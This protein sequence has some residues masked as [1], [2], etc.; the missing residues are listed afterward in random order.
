M[1]KASQRP[2]I[3][4]NPITGPL[5]QRKCACGGTPGPTGECEECRKK[6]EAATMQRA[7]TSTAAVESVPPVVH[8][9][10]SSPGEPL[11]AGTR[12]S[13]EPRFGHDFSQVRVHSDAKAAE[14][15]R[16]VNAH[17]YTVG[18]NVVFASGQYM[19]RSRN[20]E[21]LLAHE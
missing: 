11:D 8:E 13:M 16:A 15:A 10:L 9:V 20:G 14:S 2:I 7:A 4:P 18:Q 6:R 17:A 3:S 1:N 19:P 12:A 21:Q 5:L